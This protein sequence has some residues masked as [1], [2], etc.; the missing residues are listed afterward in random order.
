LTPTIAEVTGYTRYRLEG[1][2]DGDHATITVSDRGGIARD[3]PLRTERNPRLRGTKHLVASEQQVLV[4]RGRA[5]GR[6]IVIVPEMKGGE[7]TGLT[8][9]H[10]RFHDHVPVATLR[11]ALAGYRNRYRVLEDAVTE[12]EPTFREDLLESVPLDDLFTEPI[13]TL[14]DRWR[15]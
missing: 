2:P 4:A 10:V 1:Q 3:L 14:A 9:L 11:T 5:D 7:T 15:V 12:T 8:L 6:L 13:S